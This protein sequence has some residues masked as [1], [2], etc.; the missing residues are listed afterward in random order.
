MGAYEDT[1][2]RHLA[3]YKPRRWGFVRLERS[4]VR[5]CL[6]GCPDPRTT[7]FSQ[8][9]LLVNDLDRFEHGKPY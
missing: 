2:K 7:L 1:T 3:S 4:S 9:R 5:A 6:G 8:A